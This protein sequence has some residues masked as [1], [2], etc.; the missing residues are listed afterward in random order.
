MTTASLSVGEGA[1][2]AAE[3]RGRRAVRL[4]LFSVAALVA[5]MVLVG[6]ATRLTESGLSITEW[7]PITGALLPMSETAWLAEFE[8]YKQIPQYALLNEGMTL[9][10]FKHIYL[11]EWGH[12][13]LGRL[14]GLVY[15]LPLVYFAIR[16][17]VRGK[18]LA[19]L[20]AIGI[21]GGLQGAIGWIMVASGLKPGMTAVAPVRLMA[22]LVTA[23]LIYVALIWVAVG[24]KSQPVTPQE[25]RL[26]P[27]ATLVLVLI[28]LQIALGALVAGLDAG[29]VYNTWPLMDGRLVPDTAALFSVSPWWRNAF[30]TVVTVQFNHRVGG[31][32]LLIAALLHAFAARRAAPGTP[33]ARRATGMAG[34]VV[35]QAALG[36]TTLVLVVPIWAA[37]LHQGVAI[38]LLGHASAH[39]R[40]LSAEQGAAAPALQPAKA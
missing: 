27:G 7:K 16:G 26:A 6:G 24:L 17:D 4:W 30:E 37:L 3:A 34:I 38:L 18:L 10:Q 33:A 14:I 19:G 11:W 5:L 36:I 13:L 8:K 29:L 25:R 22:H 35:V 20:L 40:L 39:R 28:V 23:C 12:R 2:P 1:R 32:V 21:L 9:A 31:Y 15:L